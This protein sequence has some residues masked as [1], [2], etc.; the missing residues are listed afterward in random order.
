MSEGHCVPDEL[1]VADVIRHNAV[2]FVGP[3]SVQPNRRMSLDENSEGDGHTG[4]K[5]R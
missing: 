5:T 3:P 1:C 4:T 2:S